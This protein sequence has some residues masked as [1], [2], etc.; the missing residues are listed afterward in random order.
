LPSA[1]LIAV[2]DDDDDD[3]IVAS[4]LLDI[5]W[6]GNVSLTLRANIESDC[7]TYDPSFKIYL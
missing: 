7:A 6:N 5:K 3:D 4:I 2:D 1:S